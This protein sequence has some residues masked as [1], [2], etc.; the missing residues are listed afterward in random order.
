MITKLKK[1]TESTVTAVADLATNVTLLSANA[2]RLGAT[3]FND[4]SAAL[5]V[6]LGA[7]ATTASYTVRLVQY[8]LYELP[9]G[10]TGRVDGIWAT[11]PGDGAARITE[12]V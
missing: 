1:A 3:I 10:Y 5:Y 11:D 8:A 7:T 4:S 6:K 12:F 2:A 9:Y